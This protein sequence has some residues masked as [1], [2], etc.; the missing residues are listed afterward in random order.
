MSYKIAGI[1]VHKKVLRVV[2]IIDLA[3]RARRGRSGD[4][5]HGAILAI[6]VVGIGT[7]HAFALGP[8]VLQ[9]CPAGTQA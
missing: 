8:G 1:D 4:G 3:A 2:V 7:P 5:I 9:P 6:G